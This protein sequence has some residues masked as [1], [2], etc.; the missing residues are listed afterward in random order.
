MGGCKKKPTAPPPEEKITVGVIFPMTG[1]LASFGEAMKYAIDVAV[2]E[3]NEAG[4]ILGKKVEYILKDDQ[5][6][7]DV[8]KQKAQEIIN[9]GIKVIIGAAASSAT[10]KASEITVPNN[11]ILISPSSTSPL[12]TDLNDNDLVFRTCPSDAFQGKIIGRYLKENLGVNRAT[13]LY[14]KNPYGIGLK[15]EFTKEFASRGGDTLDPIS[16][17]EEFEE[18]GTPPD[19]TPYIDSLIR[20][21]P[22][23]VVLVAYDR[24]GLA[25][26]RAKEMNATFTWFG[27]DG[28]QTQGFLDNAGEYAEGIRGTAPYHEEGS[29]YDNF[30]QRYKQRSGMDPVTFI[31]NTY[32]AFIVIALAIQKAGTADDGMK[33]KDALREVANYSPNDSVV[34]GGQ[35][36]KAKDLIAKGIGI[37]YHGVSG[38]INFDEKGDV[39]I[40]PYEVWEIR[41]GKFVH[42]ET[43]QP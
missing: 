30:A 8:A 10:I 32:D 31:A 6:N 41:G 21:N 11:A 40:A 18:A 5:T 43:I 26:K 7:P 39:I 27:C 4:G 34:Y 25:V 28:I 33:I 16:Y 2:D 3:I 22:E 19:F 24:G 20:Q 9:A 37:D 23:Y 35:F 14:I 12:I 29:H 15:N 36:S 42:I 38:P 1:G 17:P 13:A